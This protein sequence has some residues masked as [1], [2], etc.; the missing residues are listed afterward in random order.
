MAVAW[1]ATLARAELE[2]FVATHGEAGDSVPRAGL[3][4]P[5]VTLAPAASQGIAMTLHELATN[6][7]KH[8]ALSALGGR[9]RLSWW[10][11]EAQ[12]VLSLRWE[13]SGGPTVTPP[14]RLS[15]GSRVIESTIRRQ[16]GG[17]C[18]TTWAPDGIIFKAEVPLSRVV[19]RDV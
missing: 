3:D 7:T 11:N 4:G 12:G 9:V 8:G 6:A 16:L 18:R 15:F 10:R 17:T 19:L 2:A 13:E 14:S 1:A 5:P